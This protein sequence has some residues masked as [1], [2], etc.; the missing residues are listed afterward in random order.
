MNDRIQTV[1]NAECTVDEVNLIRKMLK[2][3]ESNP[4]RQ[5]RDLIAKIIEESV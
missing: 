4:D 5:H 2:I 3:V 1:I